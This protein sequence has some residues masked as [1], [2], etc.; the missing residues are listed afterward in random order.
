LTPEISAT[1]KRMHTVESV[2]SMV[3]LA[4]AL[5]SI[6]LEVLC[7]HLHAE[8]VRLGAFDETRL[9]AQVAA[10]QELMKVSFSQSELE[11]SATNSDGEVHEVGRID[12][13]TPNLNGEFEVPSPQMLHG[14]DQL[15]ASRLIF[16]IL[17]EAWIEFVL[18]TNLPAGTY[19]VDI[20]DVIGQ[21]GAHS[22]GG[23]MLLQMRFG[24]RWQ[25][26][27][28]APRRHSPQHPMH[29]PFEARF[30]VPHPFDG[31]R[32]L[33]SAPHARPLGSNSARG[34]S[35]GRI[36]LSHCAEPLTATPPPA[37]KRSRYLLFAVDRGFGAA[38]L[39]L[40]T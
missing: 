5:V 37:Q 40:C 35:G 12:P 31:V 6:G 28:G 38:H 4:L 20:S 36:T 19:R 2:L 10:E 30:I 21:V 32:L 8:V 9:A 27:V 34:G 23:C 7:S 13:M 14:R 17:N 16:P 24:G 3:M 11:A 15:L 29:G 22:A 1:P 25:P 18:A 39:G 26:L 33:A